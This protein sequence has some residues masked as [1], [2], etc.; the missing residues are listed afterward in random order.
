MHLRHIRPRSVEWYDAVEWE[1]SK[2]GYE[3]TS[4]QAL[5]LRTLVAIEEMDD[6]PADAE[7]P[8]GAGQPA[9]APLAA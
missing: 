2:G 7:A 9:Q 1:E 3:L 6:G 5:R 4:E 8:P